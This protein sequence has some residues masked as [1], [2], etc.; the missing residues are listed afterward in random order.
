[1]TKYTVTDV[2]GNATIQ[3]MDASDKVQSYKKGDTFI[4]DINKLSI[5]ALN[6]LMNKEAYGLVNREGV[7]YPLHSYAKDEPI[8]DTSARIITVADFYN[9]LIVDK[10]TRPTTKK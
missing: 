8:Y 4:L 1:M 2:A 5:E 7:K 10:L 3:I 6:V 9:N